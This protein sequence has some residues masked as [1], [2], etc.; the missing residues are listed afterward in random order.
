MHKASAA[1]LAGAAVIAAQLNG[2][3]YGPTPDHPRTAAW[4]AALRKPS[5]TPP[6]PVFAV[7]WT[8]L[9]ALLGYS[10]Y[11]LLMAGPSP[12]RTPALGAWAVNLLGVAGFFWVLFG[13]KLLDEALEVTS[14]MVAASAAF[15]VTAASVD[16]RAAWAD[17]PLLG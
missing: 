12:R 10:G 6:G 4:Y 14:G 7:A 11:R 16:R 17:L 5:Y 1:V 8:G 2:R 15:V 13:R 3:R 9:D